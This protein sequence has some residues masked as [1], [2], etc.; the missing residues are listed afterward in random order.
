MIYKTIKKCRIC[1]NNK[2]IK[3]LDLGKQPLA[4]SFLN[5][6]E[7]KKEKKY[8][9]QM[10][11]CDKCFLS[12]LSIVI[13]PK[14]IFSDYDYLSS[15]SKP[16]QKHYSQLCAEITKKFKINKNDPIIDIGCNDG[17]LLKSYA[18]KFKN[19]IGVEPSNASSYIRDKR[20]YLFKDFFSKSVSRKIKFKFP[21]IKVATMTNVLAHIDDANSVIQ[22]VKNILH[23]DGIFVI[24][25]PYIFDM[26]QKGLFDLIYHEHLS[27][28]SISSLNRLFKQNNMRIIDLKKINLGAS[29]PALR[30]IASKNDSKFKDYFNLNKMIHDEKKRGINK[31]KTYLNFKKKIITFKSEFK[32]LVYSIKNEKNK[33]ACF[34]AP[35][36]GN[37]LLNYLNFK[38]GTLEF[39]TENNKKKIGKYLPGTHIRILSDEHLLKQKIDYAILLSWNYKKFFLKNSSFIK[40]GGKFLTPFK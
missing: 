7:I 13:N 29:G 9:L 23:K 30:I 32:K 15:S 10:N 1:D 24:E 38:K 39:A 26:L 20:I 8:P 2:L 37:T 27:Y 31:L 3:Y 40:K 5:F 36:K 12:Q 6:P 35:A 18:K 4:N 16:L 21:N 28:F 33:V 17:I 19:L 34:T 11:F 14:Y 25:V 22:N